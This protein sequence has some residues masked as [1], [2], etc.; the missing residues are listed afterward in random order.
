M[1]YAEQ[2]PDMNS[3]QFIDFFR[4]TFSAPEFSTPLAACPDKYPSAINV[5][6]DGSFKN[7]AHP[8]FGFGGA[9]VWWPGRLLTIQPQSVHE[10]EAVG[11]H[12]DPSGVKLW[13]PVR[14]PRLSSTRT[15]ISAAICAVCCDGPVHIRYDSDNF[16]KLAQRILTSANPATSIP[17]KIWELKPDGDLWPIFVDLVIQKGLHSV[18]ATWVKGHA[19]DALVAAGIVTTANKIGNDTADTVANQG[20]AE[21]SPGILALARVYI[22]RRK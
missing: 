17:P 22:R 10:T 2:P 9:G 5:Y 8:L 1:I 3:R 16:V 13:G 18:W 21:H 20:V 12:H 7:P 11:C 14:G 15:E 19:T 6:P 4:G